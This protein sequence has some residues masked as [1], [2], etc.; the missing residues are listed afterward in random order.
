[1]IQRIYLKMIV[2][3]FTC[4]NDFEKQFMEMYVTS[5]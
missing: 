2:S 4:L 3:F 1:M 5:S